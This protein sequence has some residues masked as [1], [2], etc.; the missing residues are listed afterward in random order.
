MV[1]GNEM[2]NMTAAQPKVEQK[3]PEARNLVALKRDTGPVEKLESLETIVHVRDF[4]LYYGKH[5]ALKNINIEIPKN[6]VTALIGP[7]GCGKSTL[8][9]SINRMNDLIDNVR[10]EGSILLGDNDIYAR[11]QDVIALRKHCGMVFQKTNPFPKSIFENVIYPN[12]ISGE[13]NKKKLAEIVE[14]CLKR[15]ALWEEVKHRLHDNAT[16]LS[17]GQQ[18]RLCIAR[19]I[20][21]EPDVL[22][23]DE[24]C[25]ALDPIA[26]AKIEELILDLRQTYTVVIVTHNMQ[27]AARI[28]DY[29]AFMYLGEIIEYGATSDMFLKPRLKQTED[30]LTGRFG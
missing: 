27:Q 14:R 20:A 5:H 29:T 1:E 24:P 7:S 6:R 16:A 17:G 22:L 30:Y 4:N 8:L 9:R 25:S 3:Q 21:S 2:A 10:C 15:T 18:Q 28:A 26:T 12:R 13:T 19:G 11:D 23:M